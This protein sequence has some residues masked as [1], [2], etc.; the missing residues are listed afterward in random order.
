MSPFGICV[1]CKLAQVTLR[2]LADAVNTPSALSAQL[3]RFPRKRQEHTKDICV[4]GNL[5]PP[6]CRPAL[7]RWNGMVL[8]KFTVGVQPLGL[9]PCPSLR[10]KLLWIVHRSLLRFQNRNSHP[11]VGSRALARRL[12]RPELPP[13]PTGAPTASLRRADLVRPDHY[14]Y[15]ALSVANV[16]ITSGGRRHQANAEAEGAFQRNWCHGLFSPAIVGPTGES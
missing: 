2:L 5:I 16:D 9:N 14:R 13:R 15:W 11:W 12:S 1:H 7:G 8:L 4:E 6:F 10:G 3:A